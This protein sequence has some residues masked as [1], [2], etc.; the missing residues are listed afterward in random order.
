MPKKVIN[1]NFTVSVI[2]DGQSKLVKQED[3]AFDFTP[4]EVK[5]IIAAHGD[6]GL[7]DPIN[8]DK[9]AG[10][11]GKTTAAPAADTSSDNPEL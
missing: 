5:D 9:S 7:R 11:G 2:R 4:Q 8:E 10:K 3:G 1:G 6:D